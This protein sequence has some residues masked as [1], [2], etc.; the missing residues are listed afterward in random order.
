MTKV[1]EF[2]NNYLSKFF[3]LR[4]ITKMDFDHLFKTLTDLDQQLKGRIVCEY[5]PN[6]YK[7]R[8]RYKEITSL[9]RPRGVSNSKKIRVGN[10]SDGGY[11]CLDNF[12][13]VTSAVSLGIKD[14]VTWDIDI[15]KRGIDVYQYDY[16]IDHLPVTHPKFHFNKLKVSSEDGDGEI[17][18][19]SILRS[20]DLLKPKSVFLKMDIE[21]SEW[22][23]LLTASDETLNSFT[24]IVCE[25][26]D[27]N[28]IISDGFYDKL[29]NV[30]NKLKNKFEVFHIHG[31]NCAPLLICSG[32][33]TIPQVLEISFANKEIFSFYDNKEEFPTNLDS[34]SSI[35]MPDYRIDFATDR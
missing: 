11:V 34:P 31:N 27:F 16:T 33:G 17:S 10:S 2:V 12:D 9:I 7:I 1:P 29:I 4:L 28:L 26:H 19:N 22:E 6:T 30:L 5:L 15:A 8:E 18:L 32:V 24:Q 20:N 14:D 35:A 23:T 21:G 3:G 13:N 25:L